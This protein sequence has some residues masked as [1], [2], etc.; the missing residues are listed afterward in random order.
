MKSKLS[1]GHSELLKKPICSRSF[2]CTEDHL[3][4]YAYL[5]QQRVLLE[6]QIGLEKLLRVYKLISDLE[7]EA[8]AAW[9][10]DV[11]D[12]QAVDYS[13]LAEALGEGNEGLIDDVVRLA[14]ADAM[15]H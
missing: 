5:E 3:D 12:E 14:V 4:I 6:R 11:E 15:Y 7:S 13:A 2:E 8:S 9:E 1:F 10:K